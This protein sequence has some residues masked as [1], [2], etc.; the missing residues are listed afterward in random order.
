M[1]RLQISLIFILIA[2]FTKGYGQNA[3]PKYWIGFT[4]KNNTTYS[5]N[6]PEEFLS[7]KAL[8]RR[9]RQGIIITKEDLPVDPVY[10]DS[11][12]ALGI[13]VIN[14]SKWMNGVIAQSSD[15]LLMD[16]LDKISFIKS[17]PIMIEPGH[18]VQAIP[19][20]TRNQQLITALLIYRS[21]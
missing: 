20:V 7:E 16:T 13:S 9:A 10:V 15:T 1:T 12:K 8:D 3:A 17:S 21:G 14:I 2:L 4:D 18:Y 11:T 6:S 19:I 5:V